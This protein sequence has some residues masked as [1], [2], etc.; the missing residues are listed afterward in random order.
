MKAKCLSHHFSY[1]HA[2]GRSDLNLICPSWLFDGS[3]HKSQIMWLFQIGSGPRSNAG[4]MIWHFETGHLSLNRHAAR[5]HG[6][7][8]REQSGMA[9]KNKHSSW[10][11]RWNLFSPNLFTSRSHHSRLPLCSEVAAVARQRAVIAIYILLFCIIVR[12]LPL[13]SR[14]NMKNRTSWRP[15]PPISLSTSIHR[16][17]HVMSRCSPPHAGRSRSVTG[18]PWRQ[19]FQR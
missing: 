4:S 17:L 14:L 3:V 2:A 6:H 5:A 16:V 9:N 7:H 15:W 12:L 1:V 19:H 18:W 8:N 10:S 11:Y 13:H